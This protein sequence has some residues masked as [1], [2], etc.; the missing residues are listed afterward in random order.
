[1]AL[2]VSLQPNWADYDEIRRASRRR[3]PHCKERMTEVVMR[4]FG[5][6]W[7]CGDCRITVFLNGGIQPWRNRSVGQE[8][9]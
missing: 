9:A 4:D 1:M 6:R 5:P 2:E 8:Q 3:C 7:Q